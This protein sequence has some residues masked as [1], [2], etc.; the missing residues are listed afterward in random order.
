MRK[1][2]LMMSVSLDGF[3]E[4][5]NRE[6]HWHLVDDKLHS[7][8]NQETQGH[9]RLPP[10]PRPPQSTSVM[11]TF[12]QRTTDRRGYVVAIPCWPLT[13]H[14]GGRRSPR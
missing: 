6:L 11:T 9:G 2:M 3:I 1:I 8:L 14:S 10:W 7:H 12:P 5:P 4:G 13:A